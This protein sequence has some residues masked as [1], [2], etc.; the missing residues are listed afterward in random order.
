MKEI[1]GCDEHTYG[2]VIMRIIHTS[3]WHFGKT[4]EG[5]NR[6]EEQRQ[7]AHELIAICDREQ[8]DLVLIAGD[9]YQTVNPSAE[10]ETLFYQ[11]INGLSAGG[12]RG[13]VVIA[14]NHDHADRIAAAKPL[15][16]QLG[17]TLI[18]LPKEVL[19]STQSVAGQVA[20]VQAGLGYVELAIPGCSESV[21][22]VALP[23]PSESRWQEVLSDTLDERTLQEKYNDRIRT[24][25]AQAATHFRED[26]IN[27]VMSHVYVRGGLESDSEIQIQIGG[28]YAVDPDVF[29]RSAQYVA[30]GH[31]HRPQAVSHGHDALGPI[32]RYAGSPLSYSFSEAGQQKSVV[33]LDASPGQPITWREIPLQSGKSLV[34]WK[35]KQ[36]IEQV[37]AWVEEGRDA[38]AWIDLEVHVTTSLQLEEIHQ[39]RDLHPGFV[40]IRPILPTQE[41]M[42][43]TE[44][45]AE[46]SLSIEEIFRR[47]YQG[48]IGVPPDDAVVQLFLALL[49]EEQESIM[50]ED[51][52]QELG[53]KEGV[54]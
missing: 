29:P 40:H 22:I 54:R 36:G 17:I 13:V 39:L 14:G 1:R 27:L 20:R 51:G 21:V 8:V 9:I 26:T 7:F 5:R 24:F 50:P 41:V 16:D 18:G 48:K 53:T 35:A 49:S 43:T 3:D 4:L 2:G 25:F 11:T 42:D 31:L 12:T 44:Q 52:S 34:C 23:Y 30:L 45:Q 47:F 6:L 33:L 38:N 32:I 10:A 28:A 15:A 19:G 37:R 46:A